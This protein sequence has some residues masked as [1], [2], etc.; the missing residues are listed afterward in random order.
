MNYY[1]GT[2]LVWIGHF[3]GYAF[4]LCSILPGNFLL[5]L[6]G[7]RQNRGFVTPC[8]S[9]HSDNLLSKGKKK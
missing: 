1:D 2:E 3:Y 8:P 4:Y 7:W 6:L 5:G 9:P